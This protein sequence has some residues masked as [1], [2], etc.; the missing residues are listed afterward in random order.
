[1]LPGRHAGWIVLPAARAVS[2]VAA[3]KFTGARLS[4]KWT[5][6]LAGL[7]HKHWQAQVR[8]VLCTWTGRR[9]CVCAAS[10]LRRGEKKY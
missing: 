5:S 4:A 9:V 2:V 10:Q 1:M 8:V 3:D 6:G 7:R